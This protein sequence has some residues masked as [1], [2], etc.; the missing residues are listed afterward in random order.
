MCRPVDV[1]Q[2]LWRGCLCILH[3]Q[4]GD[5]FVCKLQPA[6]LQK[7]DIQAYRTQAI[8]RTS[9]FITKLLEYILRR[10][11]YVLVCTQY[12]LVCTDM[13]QIQTS[14]YIHIMKYYRCTPQRPQHGSTVEHGD[15]RRVSNPSL[16]GQGSERYN[17][18]CTCTYFVH[19]SIH[20]SVPGTYHYIL[21]HTSTYWYV[22]EHA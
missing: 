13:H 22:L 16:A 19:N 17:N 20:M 7:V 14:I 21:V 10:Y 18:V 8:S 3:G 9:L 12:I 2:P 6:W 15:Q 4:Y 11:Q 1:L 5:R